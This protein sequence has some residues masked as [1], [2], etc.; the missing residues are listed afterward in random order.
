MLDVTRVEG[1]PPE[2]IQGWSRFTRAS[3]NA[4]TADLD[5]GEGT[6]SSARKDTADEDRRVQ[7]DLGFWDVN[8]QGHEDGGP[9]LNSHDFKCRQQ[10]RDVDHKIPA[11]KK[12]ITWYQRQN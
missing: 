1:H 10:K 9:T 8:C 7:V 4:F 11:L 3:G 2:G 6:Q 5:D 12:F